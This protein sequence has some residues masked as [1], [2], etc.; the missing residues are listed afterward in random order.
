M[1]HKNEARKTKRNEIDE[2]QEKKLNFRE[3]KDC[4]GEFHNSVCELYST[5]LQSG[6]KYCETKHSRDNT[7]MNKRY[8]TLTI[9]GKTII[10]Y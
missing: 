4:H 6:S 9:R 2:I 7:E 5:Y 10:F 1:M 8:S 3:V